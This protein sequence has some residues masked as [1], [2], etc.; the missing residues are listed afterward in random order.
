MQVGWRMRTCTHLFRALCSRC[1][2]VVNW[3]CAGRHFD[4][5]VQYVCKRAVCDTDEVRTGVNGWLAARQRTDGLAATTRSRLGLATRHNTA[6]LDPTRRAFVVYIS[7]F[8]IAFALE[9][10]SLATERQRRQIHLRPAYALTRRSRL[11]PPMLSR[12][13][14]PQPRVYV[15]ECHPP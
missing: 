9:T 11:A 13:R 1:S 15:H 7:C 8:A 2:E 3:A 12:T 4:C 6:R 10:T 14:P 5:V